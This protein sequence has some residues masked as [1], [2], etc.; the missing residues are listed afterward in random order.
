MVGRHA[1]WRMFLEIGEGE[2]EVVNFV[3]DLL[4]YGKIAVT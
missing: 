1:W 3:V 2:L 4:F